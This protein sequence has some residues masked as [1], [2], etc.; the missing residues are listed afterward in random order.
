MTIN[1]SICRLFLMKAS[2]VAGAGSRHASDVIDT[3]TDDLLAAHKTRLD[4][5]AW[6]KAEAQLVLRHAEGSLAVA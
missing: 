3:L 2:Q 5:E 6:L 4:Y 1:K